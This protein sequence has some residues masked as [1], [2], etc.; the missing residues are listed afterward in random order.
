M[1]S[2][3]GVGCVKKKLLR[4]EQTQNYETNKME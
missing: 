4:S 3:Q 2:L 1:R